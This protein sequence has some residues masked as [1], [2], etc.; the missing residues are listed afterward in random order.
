MTMTTVLEQA[1]REAEQL[2]EEDQKIIADFIVHFI[3]PDKE[4]EAE[5][6]ALVAT[7]ESQAFLDKMAE[8]VRQKRAKGELLEFD[9]GDA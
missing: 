9:P 7:P 5:W 6:D 3:H 1:F 2:P 8:K 4:E